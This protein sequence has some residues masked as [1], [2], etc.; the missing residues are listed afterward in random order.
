MIG[1]QVCSTP[2]STSAEAV[3]KFEV[4]GDDARS[5]ISTNRIESSLPHD[6]NQVRK[7][8]LAPNIIY[9]AF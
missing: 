7:F 3:G 4:T 1:P 5:A 2:A 8:C 6:T 9:P